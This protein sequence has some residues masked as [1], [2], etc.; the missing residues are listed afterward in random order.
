MKKIT[1]AKFSQERAQAALKKRRLQQP[2]S[3]ISK[4]LEDRKRRLKEW[5][6]WI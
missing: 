3:N 4:I 6:E 1:L 2:K 5:K